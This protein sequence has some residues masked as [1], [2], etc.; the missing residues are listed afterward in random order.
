MESKVS[1]NKW[2]VLRVMGGKEKKTKLFVEKEID[3]LNLNEFVSQILIPT[4]KVYQIKNGKK[5]SRD[6]WVDDRY[7][8]NI[9]SFDWSDTLMAII[10]I[11]IYFLLIRCYGLIV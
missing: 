9:L 8:E 10:Y 5:V 4:E 7:A 6:R 1:E 2:Y 11:G 3:R